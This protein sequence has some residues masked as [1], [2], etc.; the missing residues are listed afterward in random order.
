VPGRSDG[1]AILAQRPHLYW[2]ALSIHRKVRALR[3]ARARACD[4]AWRGQRIRCGRYFGA[5]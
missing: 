5:R 2:G 1:E 3:S 4:R